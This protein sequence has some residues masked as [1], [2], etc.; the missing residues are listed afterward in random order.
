MGGFYSHKQ[1]Q[2]IE[3]FNINWLVIY[4]YWFNNTV[5]YI[6]LPNG[7]Y[8]KNST[9]NLNRYSFLDKKETY[10]RGYY[11]NLRFYRK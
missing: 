6:H 4:N 9:W 10:K 11:A 8:F 3:D 1:I 5:Q 7:I 2:T